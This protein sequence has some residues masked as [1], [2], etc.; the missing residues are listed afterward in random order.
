MMNECSRTGRVK[1]TVPGA[2]GKVEKQNGQDMFVP[3]PD[4]AYGFSATVDGNSVTVSYGQMTCCYAAAAPP[5]EPDD[6]IPP[7]KKK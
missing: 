1:W 6:P 5:K 2:F 7:R 3:S 4:G